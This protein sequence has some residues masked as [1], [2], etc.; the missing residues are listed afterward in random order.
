MGEINWSADNQRKL[1]GKDLFSDLLVHCIVHHNHWEINRHQFWFVRSININMI[2]GQSLM[3][4]Y[5]LAWTFCCIC[6]F[7][8]EECID[9]L[10][11]EK[12]FCFSFHIY[13][14]QQKAPL[15]Y[16]RI[17]YVPINKTS[18]EKTSTKR[19]NCVTTFCIKPL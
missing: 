2:N 16:S 3:L 17:S 9:I 18:V 15:S 7:S 13:T 6:L 19:E 11:T 5:T 10:S 1:C 4:Q 8:T 12:H 14:V